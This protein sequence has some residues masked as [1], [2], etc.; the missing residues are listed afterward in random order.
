MSRRALRSR[1]LASCAPGATGAARRAARARAS[2]T[3]FRVGPRSQRPTWHSARMLTAR[4]VGADP[5]R[6]ARDRSGRTG[7]VQPRPRRVGRDS[8]PPVPV[9]PPRCAVCSTRDPNLA[10][11]AEPL[12]FAVRE[13]HV[14]AVQVLLAAGAEP[15]ASGRTARAGDGRARPRPRGGRPDSRGRDSRSARHRVSRQD[16]RGSP[17][18]SRGG[19]ER[20]GGL[21]ASML[22][23]DPHLVE[24]GDRKGGTPLHRAVLA[25]AHEAIAAAARS[26]RRHSGAARLGS[27]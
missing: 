17:H 1:A 8:W 25:S 5:A 2:S 13:G 14:E 16:D 4:T 22:D 24:L 20:R 23:A 10:R 26:W 15:D 3:D 6:R 21:C 12:R 7:L 9:T 18:P 19:C 11:Y 27:G